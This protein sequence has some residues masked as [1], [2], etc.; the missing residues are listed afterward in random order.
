MRAPV[1]V[2]VLVF[3]CGHVRARA[4][5]SACAH[6]HV[7]TLLFAYTRTHCTH[8]TTPRTPLHN[9]HTY[10]Y[11]HHY[12][13]TTTHH[14]MHTTTRTPLHAHRYTHTAARTPLHT[15]LHTHHSM[16]LSLSLS[17]SLSLFPVPVG[18][19]GGKEHMC[20]APSSKLQAK[21]R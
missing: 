5:A 16:H 17:L 7:C 13:H 4:C 15:P 8:T 9:T 6:M 20:I 21:R 18:E 12:T 14:D 19:G 11:T 3:V 2:C 1:S 10:H